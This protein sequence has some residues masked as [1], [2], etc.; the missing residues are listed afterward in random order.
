M[1]DF[2]YM[3]P[4]LRVKMRQAIFK[5]KLS[6]TKSRATGYS[7]TYFDMAGLDQMSLS[8]FPSDEEIST[9]AE[10]AS[11]EANSLI[12]LLELIPIQVR[13]LQRTNVVLPGIQ[14]WLPHPS[15]DCKTD[16]DSLLSYDEEILSEAEHLQLLLDREEDHTLSR[17][18]VQEA[19][20]TNLTCA[21]LAL[22]T[23][24][25]TN[26]CVPMS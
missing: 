19:E 21:V 3:V 26:M 9:I 2:L 13:N 12:S 5:A 6:N 16:D 8:T 11:E 18:K 10:A 15:L 25:I 17:S 23:D 22:T 4:K 1:L 24:E 14:S 7:H 20:I